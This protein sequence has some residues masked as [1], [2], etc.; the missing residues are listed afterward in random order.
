MVPRKKT[1][2]PQSERLCGFSGLREIQ[3]TKSLVPERGTEKY[4]ESIDWR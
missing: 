2:N 1:K 3:R 4:R